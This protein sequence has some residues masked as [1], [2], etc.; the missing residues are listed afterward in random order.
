MTTI[1]CF[2][3][4]VV[5]NMATVSIFGPIIV[6]TAQKQGYDPVLMLLVVTLSSSFAF[7]LPM[8][9]G[10]NMA[11]YSTKRVGVPFMAANGFLLNLAA[12]VLGSLY[13]FFGMSVLLG[14]YKDLPPASDR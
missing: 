12:C 9:G 14:S 5:S 10:P 13:M 1:T 6:A 2:T 7:M 8:A 4:E 3:T 11:V